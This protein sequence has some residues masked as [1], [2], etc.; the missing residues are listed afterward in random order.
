VGELAGLTYWPVVG[1]GLIYYTGFGASVEPPIADSLWSLSV[2]DAGSKGAL[3]KLLDGVQSLWLLG[4]NAGLYARLDVDKARLGWFAPSFSSGDMPAT[5]RANAVQV[6]L[7][8]AVF[9]GDLYFIGLNLYRTPGDARRL[10]RPVL[11]RAAA[12][13]KDLEF[14]RCFSLQRGG[15]PPKDEQFKFGYPGEFFAS[16]AGIFVTVGPVNPSRPGATT[17]FP[18]VLKIWPPKR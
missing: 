12:G 4:F 10:E 6:H 15:A 7:G 14:V 1:D 9:D 17:T 2:A 16:K 5:A 11:L 13:S 3:V 18:H 8:G